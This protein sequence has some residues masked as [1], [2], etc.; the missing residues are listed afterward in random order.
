[1]AE[2]DELEELGA[3]AMVAAGDVPAALRFAVTYGSRI[4]PVGVG[5]TIQ[6]WR[7]LAEVAAADLTVARVLEPHVD[8]LAI[9][10]EASMDVPAGLFGVY[11]ANAPDVSLT[12]RETDGHW[13][14]DGTRAWCSLAARLDHALI[15]AEC[16]Q[17]GRLFLVSLR[18]PG[19][20]VHRSGWVARGLA[21]VE[22]G[23]VRF[24][25]V[26]AEPVGSPGW[27][28]D[29]PGFAWGGIGVAAVWYG[30][31]RALGRTLHAAA[32]GRAATDLRMFNL[33]VVDT[34]LYAAWSCLVR[35]AAEI[36]SGAAPGAAARL[37]AARVRG[38]VA[39][40][41]ETTLIMVGHAL[42]PAP[43]AFDEV[44]ARRVADLE[45]YVR[46]HHAERDLAALGALLAQLDAAL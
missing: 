20:T 42:G 39:E 29:R 32:R 4:A 26:P 11:A 46:Q 1:M 8:A 14:L 27:Y 24:D 33:G 25:Q 2:H 34:R 37:L 22:S 23:P 19:V 31:A 21:G 7:Q 15:T 12:A 9:L 40:A 13:R 43:M 38:V 10:R 18:A 3:A 41:V 44:H 28:I 5:Q 30:A 35:S 6:R 17:G 45:L 36:D 16:A